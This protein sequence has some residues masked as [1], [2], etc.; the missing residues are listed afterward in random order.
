MKF[1]F[2]MQSETKEEVKFYRQQKHFL[3]KTRNNVL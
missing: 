1:V 2:I 3:I